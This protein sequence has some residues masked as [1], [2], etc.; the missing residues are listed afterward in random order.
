MQIQSLPYALI[1]ILSIW[2]CLCDAFSPTRSGPHKCRLNRFVL[3]EQVQNINDEPRGNAGNAFIF[4]LG[5]VGMVLADKLL[6]Q[7][8]TVSGTCT[9]VKKAIELKEKGINTFIFDE[10]TNPNAQDDLLNDLMSS[11]HILS[12]IAPISSLEADIVLSA[13]LNDIRKSAMSN[14][15]QWIGYVSSTGVYG[16]CNGAWVAED[17]PVNPA[18]AKTAARA[19]A[20]QSWRTLYD[21]SGLPVHIYRVAGIYGPGRSAL[22][23]LLK[24]NGDLSLCDADDITYISRVHVDDVATILMTSMTNPEP[25]AVYNVAD[26]LPSTRYDVLSYSS[27]LLDYRLQQPVSSGKGF[28]RGGSKRVDNRKL[29]G[30]LDRVGGELKFP[31]YRSGLKALVMD[32][33]HLYGLPTP[34][35]PDSQ[36]EK[37]IYGGTNVGGGGEGLKIDIAL[38]EEVAAL[39][40]RVSV[41]ENRISKFETFIEMSD[42][43]PTKSQD[44]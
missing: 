32:Y 41:L 2:S 40:A 4:G 9:N 43:L 29:R 27:R 37:D 3:Q 28:T 10:M 19:A 34:K 6:A 17:R 20:E 38:Q 23:T 42:I 18:T 31:D 7:G 35:I 30:L 26:D 25:G 21:R 8:W 1:A 36:A 44:E 39:R 13:Y 12:T 14:T 16:E 24:A 5:Y 22:D 33:P 11:T 15:L